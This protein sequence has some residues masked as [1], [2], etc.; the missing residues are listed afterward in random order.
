MAGAEFIVVDPD[1][2]DQCSGRLSETVRW[3]GG[4]WVACW[5]SWRVSTRGRDRLGGIVAIGSR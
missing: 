3:A 4:C 2:A 1:R 5:G